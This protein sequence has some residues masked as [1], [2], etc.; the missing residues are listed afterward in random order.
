MAHPNEDLVRRG[1][2]AFATGD[3]D[4]LRELFAEDI[5]W[6]FPG[7]SQVS[8]DFA[9]R[10]EVLQWLARSFELTGGTLR[11]ELHDVLAGEDHVAALT[12]VTAQREGRSLDDPSIQLLH[13]KNGK[14]TESWIYPSD[15]QVSDEFWG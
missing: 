2:E 10:D 13:V 14:A 1:F 3:M 15:Q 9:G 11:I 7:H 12:R 8:G 5:V 4:A 6:H